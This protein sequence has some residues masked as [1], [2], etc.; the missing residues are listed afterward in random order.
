[1][2]RKRSV[3][4][5]AIAGVI[6]NSEL[7]GIGFPKRGAMTIY[8]YRLP[9]GEVGDRLFHVTIGRQDSREIQ[10]NCVLIRH[11][12]TSH[13]QLS[14]GQFSGNSQGASNSFSSWGPSWE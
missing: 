9:W 14:K 4:S 6:L 13:D 7:Y 3:T 11:I 2:S 8:P 5:A 12:F 1:M 10:K